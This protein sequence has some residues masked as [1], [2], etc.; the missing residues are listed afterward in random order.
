MRAGELFETVLR[1]GGVLG[2]RSEKRDGFKLLAIQLLLLGKSKGARALPQ[3]PGKPGKLL[4]KDAGSLVLSGMRQ[5]GYRLAV[6]EECAL[7]IAPRLLEMC[8][9]S[10]HIQLKQRIGTLRELLEG[11]FGHVAF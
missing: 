3:H 1:G 2:H 4:Q 8:L 7:E 9:E 10:R 6:A 11:P 5:L